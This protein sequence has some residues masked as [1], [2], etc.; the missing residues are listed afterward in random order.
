MEFG[1]HD[2]RVIGYSLL[3]KSIEIN[4]NNNLQIAHEAQAQYQINRPPN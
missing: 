1:I 3:N 2:G 4:N